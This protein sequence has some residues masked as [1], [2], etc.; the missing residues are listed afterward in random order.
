MRPGDVLQLF[1]D[2][3]RIYSMLPNAADIAAGFVDI[4]LPPGGDLADGTYDLSTRV[5]DK[6]G[7]LSAS[8][9]ATR[10]VIDTTGPDAP[11]NLRLAPGSDTGGLATD[12][13]TNRTSGLTIQGTY[14][15]DAVALNI[16]AT[17]HDSS[18]REPFSFSTDDLSS[19]VI[20]TIAAGELLVDITALDAKAITLTSGE[21]HGR[22]ALEILPALPALA[23]RDGDSEN[24]WLLVAY[25][26]ETD[27]TR[28]VML[29]VDVRSDGLVYTRV[30]FARDVEGNQTQSAAAANDGW[31]V[32]QPM[33]VVNSAATGVG[34]GVSGIDGYV[35]GL[36]TQQVATLDRTDIGSDPTLPLRTF[37]HV[38][39][40]T[41]AAGGQLLTFRAVDAA[42]NEGQPGELRVVVDL[43]SDAPFLQVSSAPNKG[44]V[45]LA[46]RA[47]GMI[48][49][50]N[51]DARAREPAVRPRLQES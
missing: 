44:V 32:G 9:V 35:A 8:S 2:S 37:R 50:S 1:S 18:I 15:A 31:A 19:G 12:G 20:N 27:Q 11:T 25:D 49:N 14:P 24:R 40:G 42:G 41:Q 3:T 33:T 48:D 28:M 30:L 36:R 34:Y 23:Y 17:T 39:V 29:L 21:I 26:G 16:Y 43:H 47:E 13:F 22:N 10:I 5:L 51:A 45:S 38:L 4:Q 6:A 46:G 7:N